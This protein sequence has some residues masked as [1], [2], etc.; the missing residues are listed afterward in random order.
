MAH[1]DQDVQETQALVALTLEGRNLMKRGRRSEPAG[2]TAPSDARTADSS[3]S[4]LFVGVTGQF[5]PRPGAEPF[6]RAVDRA[7]NS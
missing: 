5:A 2:R 1:K 4:S 6:W 7:L 3:V